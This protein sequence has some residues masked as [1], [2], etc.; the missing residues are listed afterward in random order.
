MLNMFRFIHAVQEALEQRR[1]RA[2]IAKHRARI[3]ER[4]KG[5]KGVLGASTGI[6]SS[7]TAL[8]AFQWEAQPVRTVQALGGD[9]LRSKSKLPVYGGLD[10][11]SA[12][13]IRKYLEG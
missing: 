4:S 1:S 11:E 3:A 12:E 5:T 6:P 10:R 7:A 9:I 8:P 13:W 2:I